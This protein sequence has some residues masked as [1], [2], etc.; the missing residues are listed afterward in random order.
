MN[1]FNLMLAEHGIYV[2]NQENGKFV[3]FAYQPDNIYEVLIYWKDGAKKGIYPPPVQGSFLI[4]RNTE[5]K[6]VLD[7]YVL[8]REVPGYVSN[9]DIMT[10]KKVTL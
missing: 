1:D 3:F 8:C 9:T 4:Y 2:I 6:K 5:P 7:V 10:W